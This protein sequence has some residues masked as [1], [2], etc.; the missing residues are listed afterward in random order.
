LSCAKGELLPGRQRQPCAADAIYEGL[1]GPAVAAAKAAYAAPLSPAT[2]A[3]PD[4]AYA[5]RLRIRKDQEQ[6]AVE[7]LHLIG[8]G[9][10]R[11]DLEHKRVSFARHYGFADEIVEVTA[12]SAR[13][14]ELASQ[15]AKIRLVERDIDVQEFGIMNIVPSI[16]TSG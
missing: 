6:V 16:V 3:E 11:A 15:V 12:P 1:L 13:G 2:P 7:M 9:A 4:S 10:A 8:S 14:S 5:S